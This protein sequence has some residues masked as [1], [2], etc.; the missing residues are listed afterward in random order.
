MGEDVSEA[1]YKSYPVKV[2]ALRMQWI[3]Q[4]AGERFLHGILRSENL[5]LYEI[6]T[7]QIIIEFL[8]LEYKK[9]IL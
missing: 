6:R 8:Y 3:L 2:V 5:D 4:E 7:V 9:V 1:S